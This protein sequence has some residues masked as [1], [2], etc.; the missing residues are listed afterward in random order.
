MDEAHDD[1]IRLLSENRGRLNSLA[2]ALVRAETLDQP[3]AHAAAGLTT[4]TGDTAA[5]ELAPAVGM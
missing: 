4:P 3:Q 1:A 5:E 2:E